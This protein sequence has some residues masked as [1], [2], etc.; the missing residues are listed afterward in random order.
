MQ[1]VTLYININIIYIPT[2][3]KSHFENKEKLEYAWLVAAKRNTDLFVYRRPIWNRLIME[4][5]S[6]LRCDWSTSD[7]LGRGTIGSG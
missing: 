7:E 3:N 4:V 2:Q 1:S 5:P 6:A